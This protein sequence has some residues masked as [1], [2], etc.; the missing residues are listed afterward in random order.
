[1]VVPRGVPAGPEVFINRQPDFEWMDDFW[2]RQTTAR[3]GVC[4]GL[5]G[6]GKTAFVRRCVEK[7]RVEGMF[8]DGDLHV[9]FGPVDG[10]EMSVTDALVMC[11]HELGISIEP[12]RPRLQHLSNRLRSVTAQRSVLIVLENVTDSAQVMPF[13]P[14]SASS[15]VLVISNSPLT[16][17]AAENAVV[18][19]LSLLD[20]EVGHHLLSEWIGARAQAEPSAVADLV[21]LC[22]GLPVAMRVVANRL[23]ERPALRI[24]TV[25][26]GIDADEIGLAPFVL[27]GQAANLFAVFSEA[28]AALGKAQT[29]AIA[30]NDKVRAVAAADAARLYRLLGCYP[31]HDLSTESAAVLMACDKERT[32]AAI[33]M[34]IAVGLAERD[35]TGERLSVHPLLRRHAATLSEKLDS[36]RE[37]TEALL[38]I[39]RHLLV[40]A[41]FADLAILGRDRY[42]CRPETLTQGFLPPFKGSGAYLEALG[43]LDNERMNLLA[44]QRAAARNGWQELSWQLAEALSALYVT[45]RYYVDWTVSSKIGADSARAANNIRAEARLRSFSSR[46][47]NEREDHARAETELIVL[48]LPLAESAGDARLL[49]SVWELIGRHREP[50]DPSAAAAAYQRSLALFAGEN[51]ERG[52]AF[53]MFFA[54][55]AADRAGDRDQSEAL[56]RAALP[57]VRA[58][59]NPRMLGR[60]LTELGRISIDQGKADGPTLLAEAVEVL[61]ASGSTYYEARAHDQLVRL[62]VAVGDLAAQR[63]ALT[64]LIQLHRELDSD[65]VEELTETLARLPDQP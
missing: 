30:A 56:L 55:V 18:R 32:G 38:R 47:W 1:M 10:E 14:N 33:A 41:A 15:A 24:E 50:G 7:V 16:E 11:L 64:R 4:T 44:V 52:T 36:D 40:R 58:E 23:L 9:D 57:L 61:S 51:D 60:C 5:P 46:A 63:A 21:R 31:G 65:R 27:A 42:R 35:S 12:G 6:V 25:V 37:R 29:D 13:I 54:G 17:L 39:T 62:A 43:W 22:G 19:R 49:A 59:N 20:G 8:A 3:V 2:T 28:Y 45:K 48:A 53:V 26:A 34:L